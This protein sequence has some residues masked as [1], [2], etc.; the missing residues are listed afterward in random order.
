[1]KVRW[2]NLRNGRKLGDA[3]NFVSFCLLARIRTFVGVNPLVDLAARIR[4][5]SLPAILA[6]KVPDV[7]M[8]PDVIVEEFSVDE[9]SGAVLDAAFEP[10]N[11]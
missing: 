9:R 3:R 5:E 4:H 2:Q 11:D 8:L 6:C 10:A 1:M 7:E